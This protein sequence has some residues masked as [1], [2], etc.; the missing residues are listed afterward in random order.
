MKKIL[1]VALLIAAMPAMAEDF[2]GKPFTPQAVQAVLSCKSSSLDFLYWGTNFTGP[3]EKA[4]KNKGRFVNELNSLTYRYR[5]PFNVRLTNPLDKTEV[6]GRY[7]VFRTSKEIY[8]EIDWSKY[9]KLHKLYQQ[10]QI[11]AVQGLTRMLE[12]KNVATK[13]LQTLGYDIPAKEQ[14]IDD[15]SKTIKVNKYFGFSAMSKG[16]FTTE[17]LDKG[18]IGCRYPQ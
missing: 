10:K 6:E 11:E 15:P 14:H 1:S 12:R 9:P 17:I 16:D 8:L 13:D 7:V 3:N 5:L 4:E 18:Y 2:A